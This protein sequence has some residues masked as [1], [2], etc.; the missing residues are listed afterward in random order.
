[1][2]YEIKKV[3]PRCWS[4]VNTDTKKVH[5]KCSTKK[6][7]ERQ[8]RL[9]YGIESGKWEPTGMTKTTEKKVSINKSSTMNPWILHVKAVAAKKGISYREALKVASASYKGKATKGAPSKTHRGEMD[10]TTKKGDVVF[11][12]QGKFVKKPRKPFVK[13]GSFRV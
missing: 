13:G 8:M 7:A 5:S 10:Y 4:V 6:N 1:M 9:L 12:E 11:H 3:S 2:P